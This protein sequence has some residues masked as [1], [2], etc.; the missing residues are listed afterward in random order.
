MMRAQYF[1]STHGTTQ[2]EYIES[3][4]NT[5]LNSTPFFPGH[6]MTGYTDLMGTTS[7]SIIRTDLTGSTTS[8]PPYFN[9]FIQYALNFSPIDTKGRRILNYTMAGDEI[10]VW[11]DYCVQP[12]GV[13][14]RFFLLKLDANGN[15][16][17]FTQDY[18]LPGP[19]PF[20]V[21]ATSMCGSR[22]FGNVIY[23]CGWVQQ[24]AGGIK[25]PIAMSIDPNT[26]AV[27]WSQ[28][29]SVATLPANGDWIVND[30]EES[31][32]DIGG[33]SVALVGYVVSKIGT[34][35]AP[36]IPH[37]CF[38]T[39]DA[40]TGLPTSGLQAYGISNCES[41]F[42]AIN[43]AYGY[44]G[45]F[46][47]FAV[48]GW[49][50]SWTGQNYDMIA[51]RFDAAGMGIDFSTQME[52]S[53]FPAPNEAYDIIERYSNVNGAFEYYVG[54]EIFGD[55]AVIKLDANGNPFANGEW[56]YGNTG[57]ERAVQLDFY[58]QG[59][60]N[61][62]SIFGQTNSP[63]LSAGGEDAYQLKAYFNGY[64]SSSCNVAMGNP[65]FTGAGGLLAQYNISTQQGPNPVLQL[66]PWAMG[67]HSDLILCSGTDPNGNNA[68]QQQPAAMNLLADPVVYPNPLSQENAVLT[69][70]LDAVAGAVQLTMHNSIGQLVMDKEE[71]VAEGQNTL[72]LDLAKLE[73]GVYVLNVNR[74]GQLTTHR[75]VIQ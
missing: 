44:T 9:N 47:G 75:V 70:Q 27:N 69:L 60:D 5:S 28:L 67:N 21:R 74:N 71:Q 23:V 45:G 42:E 17:L 20:E 63:A 48:A 11:G 56:V 16:I 1:E 41:S 3:G 26:G 52:Y 2:N 58:D 24:V 59:F 13:S 29:Y 25:Q 39:I 50:W 22:M 14:D 35:S 10:L 73:P 19:P 55:A 72:Q 15:V 30:L 6:L 49:Q 7:V 65:V 40:L 18:Q 51:M 64:L 46:P 61:S 36:V 32:T 68:R 8:G 31:V 53:A 33:F 34:K 4:I 66:M 38:N 43:V 57:N 12:G 54:G 62:L 37:A